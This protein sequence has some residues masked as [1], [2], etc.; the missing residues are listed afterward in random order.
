MFKS[1]VGIK[2]S[3]SSSYWSNTDFIEILSVNSWLLEYNN[4]S[5]IAIFCNTN[6]AQIDTAIYFQ[7]IV[8]P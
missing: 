2:R 3:G 1:I 4:L 7:G 6:T 5:F 8:Q